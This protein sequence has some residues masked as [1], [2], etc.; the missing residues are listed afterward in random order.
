[1]SFFNEKESLGQDPS[2]YPYS[3]SAKGLDPYAGSMNQDMNF[4]L[5]AEVYRWSKCAKIQASAS[6][7][8]C[9]AARLNYI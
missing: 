4:S 2:A 9:I 6:S 7:H 8:G 1:M 3:D 5:V